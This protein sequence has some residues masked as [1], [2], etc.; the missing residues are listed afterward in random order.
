V[1]KTYDEVYKLSW[2]SDNGPF[3]TKWGDEII[4]SFSSVSSVK[5]VTVFDNNKRGNIVSVRTG[6]SSGHLVYIS[7]D[8]YY[9][10]NTF[11]NN[12]Y[13]L[14]DNYDSKYIYCVYGESYPGMLEGK[15]TRITK[16]DGK[17]RKD[18]SF[19]INFG[20]ERIYTLCVE[21]ETV[22]VVTDKK[23]VKIKDDKID[24]VLLDDAFWDGM[25]YPTSI[26][27]IGD[28]LYIGMRGG[29]ASYNLDTSELL[30][31]E[32]VTTETGT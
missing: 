28:I 9:E 31:Y 24:E 26:V 15:I 27:K 18:E 20:E 1:P 13:A 4:I 11:A 17:W 14:N 8:D 3:L 19:E 21:G 6:E 12:F 7:A 23:I 29:I 5:S 2:V 32:Q 22:Y 25:L 30:W 16:I 10:I